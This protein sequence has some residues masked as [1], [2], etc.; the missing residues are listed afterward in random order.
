MKTAKHRIEI[1]ER[2]HYRIVDSTEEAWPVKESTDPVKINDIRTMNKW[3]TQNVMIRNWL[4]EGE[5]SDGERFEKSCSL[6][7][8]R[9]AN[10]RLQREAF[11]QR[12]KSRWK[13]VDIRIQAIGARE[14][15]D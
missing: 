15:Q 12:A 1:V 13:L 14:A 10:S 7:A 3:M 5:I 4:R 9:E 11:A 2:P 8:F 6:V